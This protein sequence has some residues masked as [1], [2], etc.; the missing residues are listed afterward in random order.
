MAMQ[1]GYDKTVTTVP[2][3]VPAG[4]GRVDGAA[5]WQEHFGLFHP[6]RS[7]RKSDL[8]SMFKSLDQEDLRRFTGLVTLRDAIESS[9]ALLTEKL[10]RSYKPLLRDIARRYFKELELPTA[11]KDLNAIAHFLMSGDRREK[12]VAI[13]S[14]LLTKELSQANL[15]MWRT[16]SGAIP[17][18]FCQDT[19]TALFVCVAVLGLLGICPHCDVVFPKER[20]DQDYCSVSHREAHRVARWRKQKK[21][22]RK[23]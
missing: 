13:V 21:V 22:S 5:S 14:Q 18:I 10:V 11:Q 20:P 19:R 1:R 2:V 12:A 6:V 16:K 23:R 3:L 9:D 8:P 15:V 17:A 7:L 4:D